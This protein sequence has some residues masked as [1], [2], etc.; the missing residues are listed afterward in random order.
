MKMPRNSHLFAILKEGEGDSIRR[1]GLDAATQDA[2]HA[3]F[4]SQAA[5][6]LGDSVERIPYQPTAFAEENETFVV[7]GYNLPKE[8]NRAISNPI[9]CD[10]L[11]PRYGQIDQIKALFMEVVPDVAAF[12]S[13]D[14]RQVLSR[15]LGLILGGDTFSKISKPAITLSTSISA[16]H[17][18]SDLL[19]RSFANARRVLDLSSVFAEA[20][21]VDIHSFL[22]DGFLRANDLSAF[23]S[24]ADE[25]TRRCI[26]SIRMSNKL[27]ALKPEFLAK[28][29]KSVGVALTIRRVGRVSHLYLP[30][31]KKD[32]KKA[33]SFLDERCYPSPLTGDVLIAGSKRSSD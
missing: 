16:V 19:F 17:A 25:W 21:N 24:I 4:R 28:T 1:V 33:L 15:R 3:E 31:G 27:V 18:G 30:D 7:T 20:T 32:L 23:S 12:Q 10:A 13:F 8:I 29:A 26:S 6:Y 2:V 11:I 5:M 9:G 14:G 22:S